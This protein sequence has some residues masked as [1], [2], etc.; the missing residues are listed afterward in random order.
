MA[1]ENP[2]KTYSYTGYT[3]DPLKTAK[4][5]WKYVKYPKGLPRSIRAVWP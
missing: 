3:Y 4:K 1:L 5:G 2:L